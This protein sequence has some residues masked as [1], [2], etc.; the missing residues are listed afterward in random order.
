MNTFDKYIDKRSMRV[1]VD[2]LNKKE[3]EIA[4][5]RRVGRTHKTNRLG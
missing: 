4:S 2:K 5:A 1:Y 3:E